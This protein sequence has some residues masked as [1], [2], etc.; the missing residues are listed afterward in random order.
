MDRSRRQQCLEGSLQRQAHP[1]GRAAVWTVDHGS[2]AAM[3]PRDR[4]DYSKAQA[5]PSGFSAPRRFASEEWIEDPVGVRLRNSG[6]VIVDFDD[7]VTVLLVDPSAGGAA[8]TY[9]VNYEF[10]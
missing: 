3:G 7:R 9:D 10:D 2:I 1:G 4:T 6:T 8:I 5:D